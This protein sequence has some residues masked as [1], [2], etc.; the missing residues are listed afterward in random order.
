MARSAGAT[1]TWNDTSAL[2]GFPGSVKTGTRSSPS[3]PK[4]CGIPA[5]SRPCR[6]AS[7]RPESTSLTVSN[8]PMLTPPVVMMASARTSWPSSVS[9]SWRASSGTPPTR[10]GGA[11][12]P[13]GGGEHDGVRVDD[14]PE[15]G[16]RPG[17]TSS[18]PVDSTTTLGL[19]R[20]GREPGPRRRGRDLAGAEQ[21]PRRRMICPSSTSSPAARTC[22]PGWA[23]P[24][25]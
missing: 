24:A 20:R 6:T 18:S 19:G 11:H 2:T 1:K 12:G 9:M 3:T 4:P 16:S 5:A 15:P 14:L 21:G 7:S 25:R 8:A 17:S 13:H 22:W 23:P 10:K